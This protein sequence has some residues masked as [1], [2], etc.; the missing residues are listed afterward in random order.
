MANH[1]FRGCPKMQPFWQEVVPEIEKIMAEEF[2][3]S[4]ITLYLEKM[5]ET[6]LDKDKYLRNT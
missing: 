2:D 3:Y 6:V 4:F 5:P 1:V